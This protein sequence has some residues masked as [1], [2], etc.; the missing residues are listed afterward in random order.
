MTNREGE[1]E[2][3]DWIRKRVEAGR[4]ANTGIGIG[5]DAAML[6]NVPNRDTL[7][8][9]DMLM[10]GVH[11]KTSEATPE[12]IGHKALAVNLS[13]IAAMGGQPTAAV[14][15]VCFSRQAAADF[16]H[17]FFDGM[18]KLAEEF[19]VRIIGGDTN[20]WDGPFVVSVTALG[21]IHGAGAIKRWM[22]GPGDWILVTGE[23]GGSIAGHHLNFMPRVRE[24][25][26]MIKRAS[27]RTMIDVSDGLAADLHHILDATSQLAKYKCGA[28]IYADRIPIR[29][30]A[31]EMNDGVS[32]LDHALG[33]GEDFELLIT[34]PEKDARRL[35]ESPP[36]GVALTHIGEITG[37]GNCQLIFDNGDKRDLPPV[38]WKHG[39]ND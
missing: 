34:V 8:A 19:G 31:R 13:D 15:A 27:V 20:T 16:P 24:A 33:D 18:H 5:D 2:Y 32:P 14:V 9:V 36:D 28:N 12:Q 22:A 35:L 1:F 29:Q 23:L 39:W 37:D 21:T 17:R 38:G 26:D 25:E 10:D 4:V 7:V 3:I 11:F 30:A 6:T